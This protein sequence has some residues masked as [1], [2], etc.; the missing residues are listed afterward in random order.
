MLKTAQPGEGDFKLMTSYYFLPF[1]VGLT[2]ALSRNGVYL[3]SLSS[4][5]D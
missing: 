1:L 2:Q 5:K 4:R 3:Q